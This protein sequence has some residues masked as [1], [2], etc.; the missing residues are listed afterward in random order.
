MSFTPFQTAVGVSFKSQH[1]NDLMQSPTRVDFV[2]VHA[3]NY[4]GAGG[5]PHAQLRQIR[6]RM[7]ITI[8][9]VG[10]SIGS[11]DALDS[12]H[13]DRVAALVKH[14]QP[15]Y[16]SEHLAWSSHGGV[17][18]GDLLP[19][20]YSR[21]LL[22]TVVQHVQHIQETL[23]RRLLLENPSHYVK[24]QASDFDE[25]QFF[26]EVVKQ[27]GCGVLLDINNVAVASHNVAF[28]AMA[29]LQRFPL[30]AVEQFHVASFTAITS[31]KNQ[32]LRIDDHAGI[33]DDATWS[34]YEKAVKLIGPKPTLIE[35]DRD[36]PEWDDLVVEADMARALNRCNDQQKIS[37]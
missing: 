25:V 28:D 22:H 9:G 27:T 14:Y 15:H 7:P 8:H 21:E 34:L 33:V 30:H 16:F 2:E 36:I 20:R 31:T 37:M 17:Y 23:Q 32:T 3:E 13:L 26:S 18:L 24:L 6:E 12:R 29:Y 1:W 19:L 11:A 10:L 4:L 35:W 5:L